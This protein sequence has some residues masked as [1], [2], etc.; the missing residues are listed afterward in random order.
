MKNALLQTIKITSRAI[1][2]KLPIR[3]QIF[4]YYMYDKKCKKY[5]HN[6]MQ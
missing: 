2:Q 3:L 5:V 1:K 4:T 6:K